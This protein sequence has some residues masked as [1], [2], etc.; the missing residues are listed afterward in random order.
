M[1]SSVLEPTSEIQMGG[2]YPPLSPKMALTIKI[3][4]GWSE[5]HAVTA[6]GDVVVV[7]NVINL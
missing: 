7:A 5:H 2:M 4:K 1:A 6:D 3:I